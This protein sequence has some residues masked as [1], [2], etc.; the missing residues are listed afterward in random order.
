[1]LADAETFVVTFEEGME[2]YNAAY[3]AA[4]LKQ[5]VVVAGKLRARPAAVAGSCAAV[6]SIQAYN[7]V[8]TS[9]TEFASSMDKV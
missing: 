3:Y 5:S 8:Q 6:Q 2:P 7:A 9:D 4:E 1:M